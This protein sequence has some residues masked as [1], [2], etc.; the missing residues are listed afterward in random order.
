MNH[1]LSSAYQRE[2]WID[3]L[4]T[5]FL[6][7]DFKLKRQAINIEFKSRYIKP[8]AYWIGD[9]DSL[10]HLAII[11]I[12]HTSENDPRIGVSRD[13]FRLMAELN[14]ENALFFFV[15]ESSNNYRFSLITLKLELEGTD[16]KYK[17]SNP[18]R[19]SFYLGEHAKTR[20]PES[21]LMGS[22]RIRDFADLEDRFSVEVVNKEFYKEI[23]SMFYSLVGG[24]INQGKNVLDYP[25][26]LKLPDTSNAGMMQEF[27]VR[28][29]GRLVFCWF[30][31]KKLSDQGNPIIPAEVL[32]SEAICESYYHQ[33]LEPLFF[34]VLNT[35]LEHRHQAFRSPLYD[36]IPFLNGG[37]FD[38]TLHRDYYIASTLQKPA[39]PAWNLKIPDQWFSEL[40][41]ILESYNF[42]IDENTSI[43]IDL[44]VDPE[45][46]GRIFENLLAEL[47]PDTGETARKASGS[48]YTP[49]VIVEY[50]V[51][52][53]LIQYLKSKTSI[54]ESDIRDLLDFNIEE[55]SL[56]KEQRIAIIDA[57]DQIKVL[58][59]ACGSGAFPIGI[60]QKM[61]LILQKV[62][63]ESI[64]WVIRQLDKI[65]NLLVRKAFEEK[66]M[67]E[68]WKYKHK[69][70]IIQN[71]IYGVDIQPIATEI[72]KLRL[73]L[74]LIVDESVLE[75]KD[76]K[77]IHPLPN[78]SFKFVTANSLIPLGDKGETIV[79]NQNIIKDFDAIRERYLHAHS[80]QEKAQIKKDFAAL[81]QALMQ[82]LTET[83]YR[84]S[85][86]LDE[87]QDQIDFS[88][89]NSY[90]YKLLAWDPFSDKASSW[91]EPKWMFGIKEGFD[92]VIGN[93][94][95][96]Q[97]QKALDDKRK[98]ADLYKDCG[99]ATFERTGDIYCLFYERGIELLSSQGVL[100][101]ITSNKWMRANYGRSLRQYLAENTKA[102]ILIDFGGFK[103]FDS[104][105][106]DTNILLTQNSAP[107]KPQGRAC[108]IKAD[109]HKGDSISKYVAERGIPLPRYNQE[110]WII[111]DDSAQKL[112]AKIE[113]IGTP[114]KDWDV[115]I[116]R[117]ILTGYN[118]AFIIS[119]AKKDE[120]IA[121]D[122]RSAEI[123][124][125][126][127]RGRD[128]KRY[129]ADFADLWLIATFPALKLNI[130]DY[131]AVKAHLMTYMPRIKQT[132][133]SYID[134]NGM[135]Q[136]TRKET[137]HEWFETQDPIA[138]YEEFEKEKV[139][140]PNMTQ[141]P[142]FSYSKDTIYCNDKSFLITSNSISVLLLTGMLNSRLIEYILRYLCSGLGLK[143]LEVRKVFIVN[144]P[145]PN[146]KPYLTTCMEDLV[147][148]ILFN[149]QSNKMI[150][151][152]ESQIDLMIYKL[153]EL[154]YAEAKLIDPDLDSVF[155]SFG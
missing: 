33:V 116:Y 2:D 129:K 135:K 14:L 93:P 10:N 11:E 99:F 130:D 31:K 57:L 121:A 62:D 149:H 104:A 132:G 46:L 134:Q 120:L 9:C 114:L 103:V 152:L 105:T 32:S 61:L 27:G 150:N 68:N 126:I 118:E 147:S 52:E 21:F 84:Q 124:K 81:N 110:S 94:P 76:N 69:M 66:L 95:Y 8:Q 143:G 12:S 96:I 48:F 153:Y 155:A 98:F 80:A 13:A 117:G 77:N 58:D 154:S 45:M 18:K 35:P 74:S 140:Y 47:N 90:L 123:I 15:S 59:P 107:G 109:F 89:S 142:C 5:S 73:F 60:L 30:L 53:A 26:K 42:T 86:F 139:V 108:S 22:G 71:A 44:S 111:S 56:S 37:L 128:I 151:A 40:F 145:I 83:P 102:R 65:P 79:R 127:L 34:E 125:P 39:Q 64:E 112:K 113:R 82:S 7:N 78:L 119:G 70:G 55:C 92:I 43:D 6:P 115:S 137:G 97:L 28:L 36:A 146:V 91:F 72:S 122:P 1:L 131:P 136:K 20:T 23:Q 41:G 106:V 85:S 67:N 133:E 24:K 50:M 141:Y 49:R 75:D 29:I 100:C 101:Y 54:S 25:P 148:R 87:T 4:Q 63:P 138:Y 16:V 19:F 17:F 88:K 144:L 38:P 3:F 51:D